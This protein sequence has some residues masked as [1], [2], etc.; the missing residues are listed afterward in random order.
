MRVFVMFQVVEGVSGRRCGAVRCGA[1][2]RCVCGC[3]RW[4][5]EDVE[6]DVDGEKCVWRRRSSEKKNRSVN[7]H[8]K[9]ELQQRSV[10]CNFDCFA[11]VVAVR[12]RTIFANMM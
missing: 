6:C 8:Q 4:Y 5:A 2:C 1:M 11:T 12:T 9:I 7:H 3:A 10:V